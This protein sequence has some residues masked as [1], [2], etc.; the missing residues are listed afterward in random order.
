[1]TTTILRN[2]FWKAIENLAPSYFSMVM[3]TGILSI[4]AHLLQ[5]EEIALGLFYVTVATYVIL[6]FATA[7]RVIF[8]FKRVLRDLAS[9]GAGPG[10]FTW[11]AGN[12]VLGADFINLFGNYTVGIWLWALSGV[13]WVIIMYTFFTSVVTRSE[14]PTI[15]EGI[16]GA[17]LI[18]AV[19]TQAISVLGTLIAPHLPEY[20]AVVLFVS[21]V[22]YL[23]GCM[24]YLNIMTLI[25][26]RFTFFVMKPES[27]TPPYWINMGAVAIATLAGSTLLLSGGQSPLIVELSPFIK[28][29]TLFFWAAGT[30]WIPLL[31]ILGI[32]RHFKKHTPMKYSPLYWGMIFPLG[33]YTAGTFKLAKALNLDFLMVIPTYFIYFAFLA[34]LW[35]MLG[36]GWQFVRAFQDRPEKDLA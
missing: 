21:L 16:N 34:W 9:H 14:K 5:R 10:F 6:W 30:W 27:L 13:L 31:V 1:M 23:L 2:R 12:C 29:F 8:F 24:L 18:A 35:T 28:G 4:A 7:L 26:Y 3:A 11:I 22:F 17:W 36:L 19:A 33:M 25:F 20:E 32:W 15:E